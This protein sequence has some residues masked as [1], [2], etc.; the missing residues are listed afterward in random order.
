MSERSIL[1]VLPQG[2]TKAE[3]PLLED[4]VDDHEGARRRNETLMKR[5]EVTVTEFSRQAALAPDHVHNS[6]P[7]PRPAIPCNTTADAR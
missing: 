2:V 6:T 5:P 1:P 4:G 3:P 7:P